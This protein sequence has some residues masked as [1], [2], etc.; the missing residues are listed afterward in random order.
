MRWVFREVQRHT[1]QI[2]KE[3]LAVSHALYKVS[4]QEVESEHV[5]EDMANILVR[6]SGCDD[7][8]TGGRDK[9]RHWR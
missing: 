8:P 6:K 2:Q 9:H 7:S 3:K 5:E 4:S 1:S